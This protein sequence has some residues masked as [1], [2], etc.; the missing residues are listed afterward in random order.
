MTMAAFIAQT[1]IG[2]AAL[3]PSDMSLAM[4]KSGL[5]K[6]PTVFKVKVAIAAREGSWWGPSNEVRD[7][8]WAVRVRPYLSRGDD[9]VSRLICYVLKDSAAGKTVGNLLKDGAFHIA[10]VKLRYVDRE[11]FSEFCL[12]DEIEPVS[13][14]DGD[15]DVTAKFSATRISVTK[16]ERYDYLQGKIAVSFRSDKKYF[17]KPI[18]RVVLLTEENGSRVVRDCILDEPNVKML[19]DSESSYHYL[20]RYSNSNTTTYGND[21]NEPYGLRRTIEEISA[22]QSDVSKEKYKSVTYEGLPLDTQIRNGVKGSRIAHVFGYCMFDKDEEAKMLGY[23]IEAWQN[24]KCISH[25]D[26]IKSQHLKKFQ[27]P[28]DWHVSF[29]Y[30]EKFKYRSPFATKNVVRQ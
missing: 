2:I 23:R 13:S 1:Y 3:T 17:K 22:G 27:I 11:Y 9:E 16:S 7:Q 19:G 20:S 26:T 14:G 21:N 24:G 28:E 8:Y 30:P 18:L 15:S 25:Y 10:L 6:E 4:F 5:V 12:M 29:Q